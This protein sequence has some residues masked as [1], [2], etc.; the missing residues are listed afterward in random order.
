MHEGVQRDAKGHPLD[1]IVFYYYIGSQVDS[2]LHSMLPNKLDLNISLLIN[3]H[4]AR[5]KYSVWEMVLQSFT[6][7]NSVYIE[8]AKSMLRF[9]TKTSVLDGKLTAM[10]FAVL[11]WA[12]IW[13][14]KF[15]AC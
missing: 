6:L 15:I 2:G 9:N 10:T 11:H 8:K 1:P 5:L 7:G 12:G 13:V 4:G 14:R 3:I